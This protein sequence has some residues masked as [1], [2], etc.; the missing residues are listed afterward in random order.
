[1][2][3]NKSN[4]IN[5]YNAIKKIEYQMIICLYDYNNIMGK[6]KTSHY[7]LCLL[8]QALLRFA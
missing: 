7:I 3:I 1:M 4:G 2:H 8:K 6:M 5:Q